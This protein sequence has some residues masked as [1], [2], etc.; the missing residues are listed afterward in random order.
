MNTKIDAFSRRHPAVN[1]LFFAFAIVFSMLIVHPIYVICTLIASS[2]Y[3]IALTGKRGLKKLAGFFPFWIFLSAINPLMNP[4]GEHVLL[5]VTQTRP[6][7]L[8]AL[9]YGISLSGAFIA[10]LI[11]FMCYQRVMTGDK[12]TFLFGNLIPALSLLLVMVFRLVALF[13]K[14]A[15]QISSARKCV[16]FG[17]SAD[18]KKIDKVRDGT[19][20]LGTLTGWALENSIVTADSMRARGYGTGK[21]TSFRLTRFENSD[22][23]LVVILAITA[24]G[25]LIP[26][27]CGS[28]AASYTPSIQIAPVSGVQNILGLIAYNAMLFVPV[29]CDIREEIQWRISISRI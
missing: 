19:V 10:V 25:T 22:M 12:F 20:V 27:L 2:A 8:E 23:I 21:R 7:T 18:S 11:W 6:Y 26:A 29:L 14:K 15:V 1:F 24:L 28:V 4:Y 5:W 9:M 3:F 17:A 16:G 13:Q